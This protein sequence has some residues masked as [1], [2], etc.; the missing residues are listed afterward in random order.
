MPAVQFGACPSDVAAGLPPSLSMGGWERS[1][2]TPPL[3]R[4]CYNQSVLRGCDMMSIESIY[5]LNLR[6]PETPQKMN[7]PQ[8]R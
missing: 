4:S 1:F 6:T 3:L 8:N 7:N 2:Q 5:A